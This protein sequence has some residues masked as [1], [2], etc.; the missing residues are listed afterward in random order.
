MIFVPT[1]INNTTPALAVQVADTGVPAFTYPQIKQSFGSYVYN[2]E[3]L[4][5]Y[6]PNINQIIGVIQY[7]RFDATGQQEFFNIPTTLDPYQLENAINVDLTTSDTM[8]ILNGNSSFSTTI[9]P[10]TYIQIKIRTKRIT[11]SFGRNLDAFKEMERIFRKPNFFNN[12]GSDIKLIQETNKE[13]RENISTKTTPEK[14]DTENLENV[15]INLNNFTG[16]LTDNT[17]DVIVFSLLSLGIICVGIYF[18]KRK[19]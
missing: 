4:Y 15:E 2:I 16:K 10:N 8:F 1:V 12:Y 14:I 13:I 3:S 11:N 18:Y 6:T 9:L 17:K 5:I 7:Q 19:K